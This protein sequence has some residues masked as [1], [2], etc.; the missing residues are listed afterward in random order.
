VDR[1]SAEG[2]LE[3]NRRPVLLWDITRFG[4]DETV[5]M[6]PEGG[7]ISLY[8]AHHDAHAMTT[9][10]HIVKAHGDIN[11]EKRLNDFPTIILDV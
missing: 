9:T 11:D 3:R 1:T 8:R 10:G 6:R 7:W 5:G 2:S 4:E